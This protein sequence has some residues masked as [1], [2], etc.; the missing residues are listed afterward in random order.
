MSGSKGVFGVILSLEAMSRLILDTFTIM[1]HQVLIYSVFYSSTI[2]VSGE[3][4]QILI[5]NDSCKLCLSVQC[6]QFFGK[7]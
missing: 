2:F 7:D 5:G 6:T 1:V 3:L 4:L